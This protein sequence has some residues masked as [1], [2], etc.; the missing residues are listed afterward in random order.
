MENQ[1]GRLRKTRNVVLKLISDLS[2]EQLNK[3]PGSFNNNIVWNF[4][5]LMAS[6][7]GLCYIR[8]GV[9][10]IVNEQ[11]I[12]S[13]KGGTKPEKTVDATELEKMKLLFLSSIDQLE[14]DYENKLFANYQP[15][16]TALGVEINNIDEAMNFLFFHEGLHTG[17]MMAL[18]RLVKE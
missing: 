17:Y 11:H 15:F 4:A 13:Y 2:I 7:Q 3:V 8:A 1:F 14:K 16:T 6:Q 9:K 10:P 18:K 5:H 12:A